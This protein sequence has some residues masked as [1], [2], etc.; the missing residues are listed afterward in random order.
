MNRNLVFAACLL[1]LTLL[2]ACGTGILP[3]PG[4][5]AGQEQPPARDA[6]V[7]CR[8]VDGAEDGELLLA[9]EDGAGI[10][11]LDAGTVPVTVDGEESS[12]SALQDGMLA[13]VLYSGGIQE[14]Y[15]ARF[16]NVIGLEAS[17]P[18]GGGYTD[19]CGL[20]L[21]VLE[22]LWNTDAGLNGG[23]SVVG[24]D[25][26]QAPGGLTGSEQAAV[27]WRFG[28][29]HGVA[30]V[31]G[32]MDEF[33]EQGYIDNMEWK[34]G[35]LFSITENE[36]HDGEAYSLPFLFFN[37]EKWRSGDGADFFNNC[38]ASW[39]EFGA[40]TGYTVGSKTVS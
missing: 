27:A 12:A 16:Q 6:A 2:V 7:L 25:L 36:S 29:L 4:S 17:S 14:S 32:T 1:C 11:R 38:S 34:D 8:I 30:A 13:K 40:W 5:S 3:A 35:C 19:L 9:A 31:T 22:D 28:E 21:Q 24:V 26:S 39:P 18:V 20:Y 33:T 15:P 10:Y 37:A 23:L